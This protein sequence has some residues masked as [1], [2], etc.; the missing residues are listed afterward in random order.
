MSPT[1]SAIAMLALT[2]LLAGCPF[3]MDDEYY[4]VSPD[5][6]PSESVALHD[7][8]TTSGPLEGGARPDAGCRGKECGRD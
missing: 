8:G 2:M 6:A 7:G 4:T 1:G 3:A 5:A